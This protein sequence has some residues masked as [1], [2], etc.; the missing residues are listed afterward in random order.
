MS[1]RFWWPLAQ[2]GHRPHEGMKEV[3]TWSPTASSVTP[4]ADLDHH[5]ATLV[6][7]D[8]RVLLPAEHLETAGS[9]AM[10]PVTMC[11]SEWHIPLACELDEHLAF[12]GRVELDLLDHVLGVRSVQNGGSGSHGSPLAVGWCE[13]SAI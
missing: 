9:M 12:L 1:Q 6:A 11:S 4:G 5:A 13:R 3:T 2:E 7:Q 8:D 10:S